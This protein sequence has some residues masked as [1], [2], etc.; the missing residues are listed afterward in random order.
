M[1]NLILAIRAAIARGLEKNSLPS[2]ESVIRLLMMIAYHESG[3]FHYCKQMAGPAL[4][5]FQMEPSTFEFIKKYLHRTGKFPLVSRATCVED[6]LLDV[7]FAAAMARIYLY[8]FPEQL[9]HH[10]DIEGL[11]RY[12]KKY[13]NTEMGKAEVVDYLR[14]YEL[15]LKHDL[16][17]YYE[18]NINEVV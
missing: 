12:A 15:Y 18:E 8:T 3:G 2:N 11:A 5:L 1:R 6:L 7:E 10:D 17:Q 14:A 9:P 16:I 4:G 13:W